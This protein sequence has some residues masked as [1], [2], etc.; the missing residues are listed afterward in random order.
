MYTHTHTSF[1]VPAV[2]GPRDAVPG[3]DGSGE[4]TGFPPPSYP[5]GDILY[6][7]CYRADPG[8][9]VASIFDLG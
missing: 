5:G 6:I 4:R 1:D 7:D 3:L 9:A 8:R 2:A